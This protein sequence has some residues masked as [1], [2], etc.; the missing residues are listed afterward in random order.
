MTI[1]AKLPLK[2]LT[3]NPNVAELLEQEQLDE[4]GIATLSNYRID[5]AS[6]ATWEQ[7]VKKSVEL[8]LQ[9]QEHKDF[10]W[11]NASN[12]KFP[13]LT[14]A[15][16]QFL[17]RMAL[18]TKRE[19]LVKMTPLGRDAKGLK[20][21]QAERISTHMSFQLNEEDVNWHASDEQAK[22]AAAII[23]SAFKKT[24]FDPVQGVNISEHV[25]AM[26]FVLDYFTKDID[27][28]NRATHSIP[29]SANNIQ[30]RVR[31]GVFLPM[32]EG[33]ES[34]AF[35]TETLLQQAA[36]EAEGITRPQDG[37]NGMYIVLEQHCWLDL[38]GDD[39]AEPYIVSVREDTGQ[40]L[41]I[42]AR[43]SDVDDVHRVNDVEVRRLEQ[44]SMQ[45][46]DLAER[47]KLEKRAHELHTEKRNHIVRIEPQLYFTRY[48]FIPSPDGG[49]YGLGLGALL[50]PTNESVNSL[51]NQL[52]DSGTMANT[53]GGFLG[54]GVK[55]KAGKNSFSP[56]EWKPV[57][58][59]GNDL[60]QNIFPLP[61]REPSNVL[62]QLLGTLVTYSEKLS[63]ATDI[64]TGVS[65]GQNTPA[66][67]SR[68]TIEQGMMLFSG[69]YTRMYRS[70]TSELRKLFQ[71]N[72][73]FLSATAHFAELTS[74]DEALLAPDDYR[75][76]VQRIFPAANAQAASQAQL[77]EKA[78]MV[79]K[80]SGEIPGFNKY[81]VVKDFL[82]TLGVEDIDNKFPDPKGP[83]AVPPPQNPLI[84]VQ[85][86]KSQQAMSIEQMKLGQAQ[87]VHE[88]EM[89]LAILNFKKE[90]ELTHAKI[91]ELEAKAAME[92]ASAQGVDSG[93]QIA[94]LDAQ[95]GA[96]KHKQEGI[97]GALNI[98]QKMH[99]SQLKATVAHAGMQ[100][101]QATQ[102]GTPAA[103]GQHTATKQSTGAGAIN[104]NNTAG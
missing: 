11:V 3:H 68:N 98:L 17:A 97:L 71:L 42:V 75:T 60:R 18:M 51:I 4:L 21:L 34:E 102:E 83:N 40:V 20:A 12:V 1:T 35:L 90:L 93:H 78:A 89:Q 96:E 95:L 26:N 84:E 85:K 54:R 86:L 28:A 53:A 104:D 15:A 48:L 88:D 10:P 7:R 87:K 44:L 80:I 64:M 13:L 23:G 69:I 30:E 6:R 81:L 47:S 94:L 2:D 38:D 27:K 72:K 100:A 29:M 76:R 31:R 73:N 65:P 101:K 62:F 59:T 56:F 91:S 39:Y 25:P 55:M 5:R 63:G 22:F 36:D 103:T 43:F 57:E 24:Y 32:T 77:Q 49:V 45:T 92:M 58:S 52:I 41:R 66:E 9:V 74:G 46:Q 79:L 19:R 37:E 99:D 67:T 14:I 70:F 16:L 82:E 33:N 61:V 8:A 50:G